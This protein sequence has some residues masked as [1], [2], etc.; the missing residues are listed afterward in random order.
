MFRRFTV[1][2]AAASHALVH[3]TVAMVSVAGVELALCGGDGDEGAEG[4]AGDRLAED[5]HGADGDEAEDQG[6]EVEEAEDE[7]EG[8]DR[9][10]HDQA[11]GDADERA[12]GF[13][14]CEIEQDSCRIKR[15]RAHPTA[16]QGI[17]QGE[18]PDSGNKRYREGD[19][20]HDHILWRAPQGMRAGTTLY[21][22][23]AALLS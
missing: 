7:S 10:S 6:Y 4:R 16:S 9:G 1:M 3:R 20:Q 11:D 12:A 13:G 23:I 22:W 19:R 8:S 21:V 15:P 17:C 5:V 2:A 18:G 14:Q